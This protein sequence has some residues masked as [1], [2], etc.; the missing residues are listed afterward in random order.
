MCSCVRPVQTSAV[1]RN[2]DPVHI[3]WS[4]SDGEQS[5]DET[6]KQHLSRVVAQQQQQQ[7]PQRPGRP[8][9]PIQSYTNLLRMLSTDKGTVYG[10]ILLCLGKL[11]PLVSSL[12]GQLAASFIFTVQT[13]ESK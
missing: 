4:S 12:F 6:R 10:Q 11:F 9:A 1:H 7:Q 13:L 5:D 8:T 2:E 3:A